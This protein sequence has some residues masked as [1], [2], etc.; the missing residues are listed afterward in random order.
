MTTIEH[1]SRESGRESGVDALPLCV[2]ET[3][4]GAEISMRT[5][6][7]ERTG[8]GIHKPESGAKG[9]HEGEALTIQTNHKERRGCQESGVDSSSFL[10]VLIQKH[11]SM[12][13]EM[14]QE[15]HLKAT[16]DRF[17][18]RETSKISGQAFMAAFNALHSHNFTETGEIFREYDM[19]S[20]GLIDFTDFKAAALRP[21]VLELWCQRIPWWQ[22]VADA[23]SVLQSQ[24]DPLRTVAQLTDAQIEVICEE[25]GK[26]IRSLL[27]EQVHQLQTAYAARDARAAASKGTQSKFTT[28]KASAGTCNDFHMGLSGRVGESRPPIFLA[29]SFFSSRHS[30]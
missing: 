1:E 24:E 19:D 25:A 28:F 4:P 26:Q 3:L 9:L 14:R 6:D 5:T 12:R 23:I 21:T 22:A 13:L 8:A 18:D 11:V 29:E 20:D 17:A 2:V 15:G 7:H 10:S 30:L 27:R 16:F